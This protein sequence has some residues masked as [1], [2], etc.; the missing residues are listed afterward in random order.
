MKKFRGL[1]ASF[2]AVCV[3][4]GAAF[5]VEEQQSQAYSH[6]TMFGSASQQ[7]VSTDSTY[8]VGGK[9]LKSENRLGI[10]NKE[11]VVVAS[12]AKDILATIK[13]NTSAKVWNPKMPI[14]RSELA[15]VLAEGLSIKSTADSK[16]TD[17]ND[18]Y[19]A[20]AWI[21]KA[22]A[23]GV[24]IGYPDNTFKPDQPITK[25]EVFATIAQ[26]IDVPTDKSLIIPEFKGNQIKYIPTWSIAATKEVV[27]SKL[28]DD[29][30]NPNKIANDEY[31]SKEQVAFLVGSLRQNFIYNYKNGATT[32]AYTPTC[33]SIKLDE[34]LSARTSNVGEKFTATTTENVTIAGQSF[35]AGSKVK[36]EVIEVSRPGLK[37]PGYIRVKFN[38]ITNDD[39]SLT[40]PKNISE[41][42]AD[43]IKNPNFAARLIGA[44]FSAAGRI[45]GVT[46]RT[47]G[48]GVNVVGS[49]LEQFGD[50]ISNTFVNTLS[51]QPKA[52]LRSLGGS[53][54]T[55]GKGIFDIGKL[56]VSGV[57]GVVY[58]VTDE[59]KYL[60]IPSTSN[61]SSLNPGEELVIVY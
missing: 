49:D 56:L 3:I 34:R 50:Q 48:S 2:G 14:L 37:N 15:V 47:I 20:K 22:L 5:A 27:A 52:G 7:T 59:V 40:F 60:I 11:N 24:M 4:S 55:L 36:G 33:I 57:F 12:W 32:E 46:G 61:N 6:P 25:A 41:A 45:V 26:L 51:L 16:Y 19:W 21:D 58:E 13:D 43:K 8:I 17:I 30:P 44:P 38:E 54:I 28:L 35:A 39:S 31:L 18:N 42:Q 1:L 9:I 53:I 23:A 10:K 29:V